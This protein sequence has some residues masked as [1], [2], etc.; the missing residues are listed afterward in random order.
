M[1]VRRIPVLLALF[2][3]IFPAWDISLPKRG[4]G[5]SQGRIWAANSSLPSPISTFQAQRTELCVRVAV[6]DRG[7]FQ[8]SFPAVMKGPAAGRGCSGNGT[9]CGFMAPVCGGA[10]NLPTFNASVLFQ[11][12]YQ[13]LKEEREKY[14][15]FPDI[16][17]PREFLRKVFKGIFMDDPGESGPK[18]YRERAGVH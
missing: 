8:G 6:K 17:C 7:F 10:V 4:T 3:E 18:R 13:R 12:G 9:N 16:G 2:P 14:P 5:A 1:C 11:A 15:T